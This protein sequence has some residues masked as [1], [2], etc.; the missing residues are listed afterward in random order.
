MVE[1][2]DI[3]TTVSDVT[4]AD[5]ERLVDMRWWNENARSEKRLF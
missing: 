1:R 3:K 2:R 4:Q 5:G